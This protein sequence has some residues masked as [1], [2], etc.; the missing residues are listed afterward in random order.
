MKTLFN[1]FEIFQSK[2]LS[3]GNSQILSIHVKDDLIINT[4]PFSS[5]P[6][7][8]LPPS[9]TPNLQEVMTICDAFHCFIDVLLLTRIDKILDF[10]FDEEHRKRI[11]I[12]D[13]EPKASN[14]SHLAITMTKLNVSVIVQM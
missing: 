12:Y 13:Q 5:L 6:S 1:L 8:P 14:F 11:V 7:A 4:I 10:F 9:F 2:I 3:E